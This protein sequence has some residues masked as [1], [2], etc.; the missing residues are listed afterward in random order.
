MLFLTLI[1]IF[2][3]YALTRGIPSYVNS[4]MENPI[5]QMPGM[6]PWIYLYGAKYAPEPKSVMK[7]SVCIATPVGVSRKP[8]KKEITYWQKIKGITL[9]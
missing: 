1:G 3:F 4:K 7:I 2:L 5:I 6:Q 8:S 9:L